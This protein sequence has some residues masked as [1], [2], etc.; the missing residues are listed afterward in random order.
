MPFT[1]LFSA[2]LALEPLSCV[3]IALLFAKLVHCH[4]GTPLVCFLFF[5]PICR[6]GERN[7]C[8]CLR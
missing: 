4:N 6:S 5:S 1:A 2:V 7:S 3:I 8:G